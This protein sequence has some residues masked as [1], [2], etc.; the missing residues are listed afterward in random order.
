MKS[1]WTEYVFIILLCTGGIFGQMALAECQIPNAP[2]TDLMIGL[3]I[4][5][6]V[7]ATVRRLIGGRRQ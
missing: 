6:A 7:L 4:A 5:V 1:D 2:N 3:L